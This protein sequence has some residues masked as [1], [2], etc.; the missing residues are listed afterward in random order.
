MLST[1]E[2]KGLYIA[3]NKTSGL[4]LTAFS[5]VEKSIVCLSIILVILILVASLI[6]LLIKFVPV[7]K[8]P[9]IFIDFIIEYINIK[10]KNVKCKNVKCKNVKYKN[11]K[12]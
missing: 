11:V 7:E 12:L 1:H 3:M 10:Y 9:N 2:N 8:G 4:F 6:I 5:N